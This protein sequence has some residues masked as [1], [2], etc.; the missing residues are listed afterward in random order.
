MA[1]PARLIP[2]NYDSRTIVG[3]AEEAL[4]R[5]EVA[6]LAVATIGARLSLQQIAAAGAESLETRRY[7]QDRKIRP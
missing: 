6:T 3:A 4:A 7:D 2:P 1:E 5:V